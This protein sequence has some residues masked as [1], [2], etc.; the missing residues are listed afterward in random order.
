MHVP[1]PKSLALYRRILRASRRLEPD[2]RDHYRRFARSGYVAHADELD[3]ERVDEIIARVEHDMDWI[4]RK[5]TG[6]GLDEDPGTPA[7]L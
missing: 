6:K 7:K 2:T 1:N 3:D 5:Y 4:L